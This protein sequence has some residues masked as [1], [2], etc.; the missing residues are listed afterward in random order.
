MADFMK[1]RTAMGGFNRTDVSNYIETLCAEH[2]RT[3]KALQEEHAALTARIETLEAEAAASAAALEQANAKLADT[4]TALA[5]T[6]GA[7]EEALVMV[8]EQSALRA[9][10][11]AEQ[12]EQQQA[13]DYTALELEAYRRAEA[14]ERLA[15]ERAGRLRQQLND[16]LDNVSARYEQTGLE[17]EALTEDIRINMKRLQD[18]LS[19]LELIFD[20]TTGRFDTMDAEAPMEP[21]EEEEEDE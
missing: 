8:E 9:A 12:Q 17:I 4:E 3:T 5:S 13:M 7:L 21:D 2:R 19:D 11:E 20:E 16:L 6:E 10:A 18:A 1:F 14:T 15:Q